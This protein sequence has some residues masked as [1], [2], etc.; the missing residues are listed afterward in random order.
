MIQDT[1]TSVP[2]LTNVKIV[3]PVVADNVG[4]ALNVNVGL[5]GM[6]CVNAQ[7]PEV[8]PLIAIVY[9]PPSNIF[10]RVIPP[11]LAEVYWK[12]PLRSEEHTSELQSH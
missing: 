9:V 12:L 5:A 1:Y 11:Q 2:S 6:S 7:V 4:T 3:W 10:R 8:V